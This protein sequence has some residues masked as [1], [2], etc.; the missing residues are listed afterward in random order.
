MSR[1]LTQPFSVSEY[2]LGILLYYGIWV[3]CPFFKY[4]SQIVLIEANSE[5]LSK[6]KT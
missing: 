6:H 2:I 3:F 1:L 4:A 5:T